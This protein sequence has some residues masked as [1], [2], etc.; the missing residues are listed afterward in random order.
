MSY[1]RVASYRLLPLFMEVPG[2]CEIRT[3]GIYLVAAQA[4]FQR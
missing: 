3:E 2:L 1:L 4:P